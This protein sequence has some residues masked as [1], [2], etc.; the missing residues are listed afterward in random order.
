MSDAKR[1][2]VGAMKGET[3]AAKAAP[4][5]TEMAANNINQSNNDEEVALPKSLS[6][7][8][9][10]DRRRENLLR[11]KAAERKIKIEAKKKKKALEKALGDKAPPKQVNPSHRYRSSIVCI[12]LF[13]DSL[14]LRF[15][16]VRLYCIFR[17]SLSA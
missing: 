7:I 6:H 3:A 13:T 16:V 14:R 11:L 2:K 8:K 9:N 15:V 4:D 17:L 5:A 10:K 12:S 1:K